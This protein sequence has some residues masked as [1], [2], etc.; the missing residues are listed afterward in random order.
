MFLSQISFPELKN[1]IK[2][3]GYLN[4]EG[5][6]KCN[7]FLPELACSHFDYRMQ[8]KC[9]ALERKRAHCPSNTNA[10]HCTMGKDTAITPCGVN[11][12]S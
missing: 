8:S 9:C 3:N 6:V 12:I 5:C 4:I 7:F 10:K 1:R 2:V 11:K